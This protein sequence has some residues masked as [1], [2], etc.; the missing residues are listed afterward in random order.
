MFSPTNYDILVLNLNSKT[1]LYQE[2][3]IMKNIFSPDSFLIK[4]LTLF[5][6]L[7]YLNALFIICSLPIFTIGA[8]TTALYSVLFKRIRGE[9]VKIAKTYF[10][11]FKANFKQST[12]FWIPY[13]LLVI[14]L[15]S[16]I[17]ITHSVLPEEYRFL[18]YPVSIA[19]FLLVYVT[20]LVFPQMALFNS[21]TRQII[22]NSAIL[23]LINFPVIGMVFI[24][25]IFILLI[26][27]LSPKC[28]VM[29]ISLLLFFGFAGLAYFFC[30]FY[31]KIF[32][33][34][35]QKDEEDNQDAEN[36]ASSDEENEDDKDKT[37]II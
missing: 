18:Q 37:P 21:P 3:Y 15:G 4:G 23:G 6:D 2:F 20:V 35:L 12:L 14:F 8:S 36:T 31:R 24:V 16:D 19:L 26:A 33:K 7:M 34:I 17:Y 25:H 28:R 22:K 11:E 5:C 13:L 30:L 27:D 1:G 29:V 9:E 32:L 10:H